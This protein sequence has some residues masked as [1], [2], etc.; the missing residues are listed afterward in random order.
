MNLALGL[1]SFII[2]TLSTPLATYYFNEP[3]LKSLIWL[4]AL[5]SLIVPFSLIQRRLLEKDIEFETL[6]K[7]DILAVCLSSIL[8]ISMAILGLG[9]FS[10]IAQSLSL[11]LFYVIFLVKSCDW[12]PSREFNFNEVK[13]MLKFSVKYKFG[14]LANYFE[15]NTDYVIIGRV[16]DSTLLGYYSF[17]YNIMFF[18]V[19]RISYVFSTIL[20]PAFASIKYSR[21][22]VLNGYLL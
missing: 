19:K 2:I 8:A 13:G 1:F 11:N 10:L 18:P 16:L 7:V 15:R 6:S 9:I 5:N 22:K 14:N 17:S 20:F 4:V 3:R 21:K 12:K